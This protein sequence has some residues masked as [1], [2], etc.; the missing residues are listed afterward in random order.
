M[1]ATQRYGPDTIYNKELGIRFSLL[2]GR[3]RGSLAGYTINWDGVQLASVTQYGQI[4]I[5][6]NGGKAVSKGM[7]LTFAAK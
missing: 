4:G 1:R 5:V 7:E 2:D 6:V 3:L